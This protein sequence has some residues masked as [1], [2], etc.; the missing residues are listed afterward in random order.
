[1]KKRL[2]LVCW[3]CYFELLVR[4][5]DLRGDLCVQDLK[6]ILWH[7]R[8][9]AIGEGDSDLVAV[10]LLDVDERADDEA[11]DDGHPLHR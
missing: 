1:M 2:L 4:V 5:G 10:E 11:A 9:K 7:H 3:R 8:A 6:H